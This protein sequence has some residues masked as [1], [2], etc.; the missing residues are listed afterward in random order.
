MQS[1]SRIIEK[2]F[3]SVRDHLLETKPDKAIPVVI[4]V[5]NILSDGEY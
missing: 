5:P 1:V 2:L 3:Y 4:K